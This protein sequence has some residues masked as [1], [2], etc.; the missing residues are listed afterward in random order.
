M[1]KLEH[2][3]T[4]GWDVKWYSWCGKHFDVSSKTWN[5]ELPNDPSMSFLGI[6]PRELKTNVCTKACT[7]MGVQALSMIT[8]NGDNPNIHQQIFGI[9]RYTECNSTC[10]CMDGPWKWRVKWKG[11]DAQGDTLHESTRV[12]VQNEAGIETGSRFVFGE[13][14]RMVGNDLLLTD[15]ALLLWV[16]KMFWN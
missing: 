16:M 6:Y 14:L 11:A 10:H 8:K 1:G 3:Y 13:V 2:L 4:A 7:R 12:N 15:T 9:N 5:M